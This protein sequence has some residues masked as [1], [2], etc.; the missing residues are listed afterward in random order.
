M[1]KRSF[2]TSAIEACTPGV[3]IRSPTRVSQSLP[4]NSSLVSLALLV[5][6]RLA[7]PIWPPVAAF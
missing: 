6:L 1:P 2:Q 5:P 7:Q 4:L 3:P